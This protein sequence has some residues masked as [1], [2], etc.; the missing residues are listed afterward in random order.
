MDDLIFRRLS[1]RATDL[2]VRTVERWLAESEDH[3]RRYREIEA[4]WAV[5]ELPDEGAPPSLDE[6]TG[7]AGERRRKERAKAGRKAALRSPWIGYGLAAAA[8]VALL[9]VRSDA[10]DVPRLTPVESTA[11]SGD[12]TTMGLSDGSV[13][14]V[15][16]ST[17]VEF[18]PSRNRRELVLDG[19]AFFA[20]TEAEVPFV[21]RTALGEVTVLGTRFEVAVDD[22][23]LRLIVV[24][25]VVTA[26]GAGTSVRVGAGQMA[27]LT[28]ESGARLIEGVDVWEMLD[29]EG[30]SFSSSRPPSRRSRRR[31]HATSGSPSTWRRLCESVG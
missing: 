11:S 20:V 13:V 10:G 28:P 18:P 26:T 30:G 14:R 22:E 5:S 25:G 6:I 8:I 23:E 4:L 31:W 15:A 9:I 29:W 17:T 19:R 27:Q 16:G 3:A 2:E 21:V 7:Q 12:V 1:G 24:E